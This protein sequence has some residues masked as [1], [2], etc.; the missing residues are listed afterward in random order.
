[1][2][3]EAKSISK[4]KCVD[5]MIMLGI[6]GDECTKPIRCMET[7]A[8]EKNRK[9]SKKESDSRGQCHAAA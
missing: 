2:Y 1:M 3:D 5:G 4:S 7:D 9:I 8:E 6:A